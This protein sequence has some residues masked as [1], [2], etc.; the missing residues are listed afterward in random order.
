MEGRESA[1]GERS[2]KPR[3][4]AGEVERRDGAKGRRERGVCAYR[5]RTLCCCLGELC[6]RA[7]VLPLH[8][9]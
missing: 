8:S 5:L 1:Q 3:V 9:F 2:R 4:P 6:E 7:E